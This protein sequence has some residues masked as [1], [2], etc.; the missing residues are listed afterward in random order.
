MFPVVEITD[1]RCSELLLQTRDH[2]LFSCLEH[3]RE[4]IGGAEAVALAKYGFLKGVV[5]TLERAKELKCR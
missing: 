2:E 5:A 4:L 1:G 3:D